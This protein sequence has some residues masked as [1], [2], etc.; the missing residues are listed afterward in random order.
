MMAPPRVTGASSLSLRSKAP[1]P[2]MWTLVVARV[3]SASPAPAAGRNLARPKS[4]SFAPLDVSMMLAGFRIPVDDSVPMRMVEGAGYLVRMSKRLV[5]QQRSMAQSRG[6]R[7]TF[8]VLHDQVVDLIV[9]TDVVQ[10]ADVRVRERCNRPCFAGEPGAHL[11]IER[12]TDRKNLDGHSTM[13]TS[14]GAVEDLSHASGA[15]RTF[16]AVRAERRTRAKVGIIVEQWRRRGPHRAI[17]DNLCTLLAQQRIHFASQ[18]LVARARLGE[19][20]VARGG[21]AVD[22]QLVDSGDLPPALGSQVH[23]SLFVLER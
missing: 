20:R 6:Q 21:V 14:V 7:F 1:G 4:S 8:E 13:E 10:S 3:R 18:R 5:Q 11:L 22:G 12:G 17:D 2:S 23:P 19:K 16:D 15:E 9:T